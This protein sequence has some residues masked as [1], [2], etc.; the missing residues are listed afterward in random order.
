MIATYAMGYKQN[1]PSVKIF[2]SIES[3]T[4]FNLCDDLTDAL[5]WGQ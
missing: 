3:V 2:L 4:N 5:Y 1:S